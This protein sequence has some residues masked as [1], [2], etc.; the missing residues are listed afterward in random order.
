MLLLPSK[1]LSC[2]RHITVYAYARSLQGYKLVTC[3]VT[4]I[5]Q[6]NINY[7]NVCQLRMLVSSG[8]NF[9]REQLCKEVALRQV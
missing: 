2:G 7:Y 9:E 6:P 3:S 4:H 1:L 8:G 5:L